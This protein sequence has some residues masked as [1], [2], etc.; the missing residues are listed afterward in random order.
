MRERDLE[1]PV[2][3]SIKARCDYATEW[4]RPWKPD[5]VRRNVAVTRWPIWIRSLIGKSGIYF[6]RNGSNKQ[7][8]Y[9][10]RSKTCLKSTLLRHFRVWSSD[11]PGGHRRAVFD[12]SIVEIKIYLVR[13]E[14]V[15][16]TEA[17][18]IALHYPPMNLRSEKSARSRGDE[19]FVSDET[20]EDPPF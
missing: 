17:D 19:D 14:W 5:L 15:V 18:L 1:R 13:S 8:L 3:R 10:G 2:P 4:R 9:I 20:L 12:R 7:L 16:A 11:R 6:V